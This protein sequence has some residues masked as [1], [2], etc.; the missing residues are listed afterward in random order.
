MTKKFPRKYAE[1]ILNSRKSLVPDDSS[2]ISDFDDLAAD[3]WDLAFEAMN[4]ANDTM[5]QNM[6]DLSDKYITLK[7][8][9]LAAIPSVQWKLALINIIFFIVFVIIIAGFFIPIINL[10]AAI[11]AGLVLWVL[12]WWYSRKLNKLNSLLKGETN[13]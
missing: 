8:E 6:L 3:E 1:A 11:G 7:L 5:R 12:K 13:E 4:I 2:V 9:A 10:G